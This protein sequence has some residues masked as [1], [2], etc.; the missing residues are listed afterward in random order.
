MKRVCKIY[1]L[2]ESYIVLSLLI[3]YVFKYKEVM[4]QYVDTLH[5]TETVVWYTAHKKI[6]CQYCRL[7]SI[8]YSLRNII[9][10]TVETEITEINVQDTANWTFEDARN[11]I[12]KP[13]VTESDENDL[14]AA[15]LLAKTDEYTCKWSEIYLITYIWTSHFSL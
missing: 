6:N 11:R 9:H 3:L 4:G 2:D 15:Q 12:T 14:I 1:E 10:D 8:P 13:T 7:I 5:S